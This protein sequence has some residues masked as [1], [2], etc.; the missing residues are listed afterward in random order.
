MTIEQI[1][2]AVERMTNATDNL[3]M[4]R[5]LTQTQYDRRLKAI[6]RWADKHYRM[7]A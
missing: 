4:A 6:N 3:F 1:E 7:A 5:R 2:R